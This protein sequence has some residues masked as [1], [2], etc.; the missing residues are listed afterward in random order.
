MLLEDKLAL[1][2]TAPLA[3]FYLTN[4][5]PGDSPLVYLDENQNQLRWRGLQVNRN[6]LV[7]SE[8]V[9]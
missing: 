3:A 5:I 9:M 1:G 6:Q 2:S 8:E 4:I 7:W